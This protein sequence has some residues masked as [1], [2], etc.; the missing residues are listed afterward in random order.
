MDFVWPDVD[1]IPD[2]QGLRVSFGG[3]DAQNVISCQASG[4]GASLVE[5]TPLNAPVLG[6]GVYA[7]CIKNVL[8]GS[9]EPATVTITMWGIGL[10]LTND[11]RGKVA[12]L[13]MYKE[14]IIN[15]AGNAVM[16]SQEVSMSAGEF[17]QQTVNFS[18]LN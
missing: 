16:L 2:A 15:Y 1:P 13:L 11:D 9:T 6:S 14:G 8:P 3:V 5:A 12:S 18:Y 17:P 4:G 10:P 7:R